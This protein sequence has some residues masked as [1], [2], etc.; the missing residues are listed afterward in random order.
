M[1]SGILGIALTGLNAAQAGIRTTQHNIANVNT[2]GYRRQETVQSTALPQTTPM[3]SFGNGVEVAT[4]RSLYS[5]FLD[6]QLLMGQS[7]LGFYEFYSTAAGQVDQLLGDAGSG[8][9]TALDSFFS[10]F[11]ELAN[12]PTSNAARQVVLSAGNNLAGRINTL[13]DQLRGAMNASNNEL[14]QMVGQANL[15]AMQI[16][17]L[18][19]EITRVES[20]HGTQSANDL[21]DLRQK[22]IT[23]LNKLLNVSLVPQD[24]GTV[25]VFVGNGQPLVLG[26]RA[27]ALGTAVDPGNSLLRVPTIDLGAG[28]M[29]LDAAQVSGGKI[30]GLLAYRAEIL[31][32]AFSDLNTLA[33]A[34]AGEVNAL[35]TG[36]EDYNGNTGVDFFTD[37]TSVVASDYARN[38]AMMLGSPTQVTA[39]KAGTGPGDNANALDLAE[40]RFEG[41]L[42][43]GTVSFTAAYGQT[44]ARTASHAA[45]ADMNLSAFAS[46]VSNQEADSRS[47]SGVNLD[48]EA[49]NLIR[50]QQAYQAAARAMQIAASLFDE[51]LGILR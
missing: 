2:P 1:S 20:T 24:G 37:P 29:H 25:G 23:E 6:N 9:S 21:R 51:V 19:G 36:G 5:Q 4:V 13:D 48:E 28:A 41:V 16:A 34:I 35:H 45:E 8:L 17:N 3:G 50:Y 10:A 49:V 11:N 43:G 32:P 27:F 30:G 26:E 15:Y 47:I 42:A 31:L 33:A 22:L 12:A 7:Q 18:N 44:I 38:M 39:A 14:G 40:L 46:L